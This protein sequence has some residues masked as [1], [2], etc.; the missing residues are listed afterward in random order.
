MGTYRQ[1]FGQWGEAI[2][3]QYLEQHGF[4]IIERNWRCQYGEIDIIAQELSSG[5]MAF[6]EVKV[7]RPGQFGR[8]I[9]SISPAK[10]R[11][12]RQAIEHYVMEYSVTVPYRCDVIAIDQGG[13]TILQHLPNIPL[14]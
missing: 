12:L 5:F 2:A 8:A 3:A 14:D 1:R 13:Q 10:E 9:A 7:R 4:L 11:S 6:V